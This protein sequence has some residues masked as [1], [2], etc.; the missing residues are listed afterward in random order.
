MPLS[1]PFSTTY[2]GSRQAVGTLGTGMQQAAGGF[3]QVQKQKQTMEMLKQMG[4]LTPKAVS[5]KDYEDVAKQAGVDIISGQKTTEQ[6][7]GMPTTGPKTQLD[8][9]KK[10][11]IADT[12]FTQLGI[13][14]PQPKGMNW[15]WSAAGKAGMDFDPATGA[16]SFKPPTTQP[17]SAIEQVYELKQADELLTSEGKDKTHQATI[18]AKGNIQIKPKTMGFGQAQIAYGKEAAPDIYSSLKNGD[19][20]PYLNS[21][22]QTKTAVGVLASKEGQNIDNM[23]LG[24]GAEKTALLNTR[25]QDQKVDAGI[26]AMTLLKSSFDPKTGDFKVPPSMHAELALSVARLLSQGGV[27]PF[28]MLEE[29]RQKTARE[30]FASM[31]IWLGADPKEV[32]GPTQD[33]VKLFMKTI[34]RESKASQTMRDKY[35][36]GGVSSFEDFSKITG[37]SSNENSLQAGTIEDGY[38]FKGGDPSD[39]NNWEQQ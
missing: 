24:Y 4:I 36:S 26:S 15:D 10:M 18:D 35:I 37:I 1:D 34:E 29:L 7:I 22:Q 12:I 39:R 32:G 19:V 3:I 33:V 21:T 25:I 5:L 8:D 38:K 13:P 31:A 9:T 30:Q 27:I 23:V 2:E 16:V 11:Q 17:K 6:G 14:K 20:A 28:Q